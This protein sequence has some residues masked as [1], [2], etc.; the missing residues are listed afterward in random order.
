MGFQFSCDQ[1]RFHLHFQ[2]HL[3]GLGQA[4]SQKGTIS[5]VV[6]FKPAQICEYTICGPQTVNRMKPLITYG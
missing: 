3:Q 4:F 1:Q 6:G 5:L 2:L